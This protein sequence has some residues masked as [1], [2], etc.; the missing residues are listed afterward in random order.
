MLRRSM[1]AAAYLL[2]RVTKSRTVYLAMPPDEAHGAGTISDE[3]PALNIQRFVQLLRS[4]WPSFPMHPFEGI[5]SH[6]WEKIG[7][8]ITVST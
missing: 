2:G 7:R 6:V 8:R 1:F 3:G 5:F 4:R